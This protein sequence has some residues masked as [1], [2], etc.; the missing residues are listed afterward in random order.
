MMPEKVRVE[1]TPNGLRVC[2]S[3]YGEVYALANVATAEI[4]GLRA[5]LLKVKE[6]RDALKKEL[7]IVRYT[8]H[9]DICEEGHQH[10][11]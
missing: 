11:A 5:E 8:C 3:E 6:E 7:E 1:R 4:E 2:D 10:G 9:C